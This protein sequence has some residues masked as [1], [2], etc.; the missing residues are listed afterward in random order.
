ML[1]VQHKCRL[2]LIYDV[3]LH[4]PAVLFNPYSFVQAHKSPL[5]AAAWSHDG[6][7]LATASTTGT[8]I[9]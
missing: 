5:A 3:L 7:F 6:A 2:Q 9:R 4:V 8:V 1:A